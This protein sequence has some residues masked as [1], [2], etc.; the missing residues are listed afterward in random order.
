MN[1]RIL[2][3][4][5]ICFSLLVVSCK[6]KK[7]TKEITNL[8][9]KD[10][11]DERCRLDF[12]SGKVLTRHMKENELDYTYASAKLSCELTVDG[13]ENSFQVNIRCRKDSVIWMSIS[14]LGIDAAR[15]LITKDSVKFTLGLTERKYFKGDFS[16]VNQLLHAELDYNMIQALM[17]GNSAEFVDADEKLKP[18]KDKENCRYLLST[19][20]KRHLKRIM[21]GE[22]QPK[23]SFQTIW[24]SP[25]TFKIQKLEFDDP[26]TKRKF[27]AQYDDFRPVDR[28]LSPF[29]MVYLI[30]AEKQVNAKISFARITINEPQK[31]PFNIPSSYDP[32]EIKQK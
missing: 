3:A 18:G 16:Y 6:T 31:F 20:R 2:I 8:P 28:F 21:E 26:Q 22:E 4:L 19:V 11:T 10:T 24:L 29:K 23:E 7:K 5:F 17:F 30:T 13:E 25:E 15:V 27:N 14:K 1:N 9:P 32:I 12:K